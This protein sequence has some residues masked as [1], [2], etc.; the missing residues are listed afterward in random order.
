MKKALI[1]GTDDYDHCPKLKGCVRNAI[2]MAAVLRVNGNG[3]PNFDVRLITSD[4]DKVTTNILEE[5]VNE[6]FQG[7][8]ETA[9]FYFS[10]QGAINDDVTSGYLVA[11]DGGGSALG[12]SVHDLLENANRASPDIKSTVILLDI[13]HSGIAGETTTDSLG[14]PYPQLGQGVTILSACHKDGVA[15]KQKNQGRFTD[16]LI[17]GLQGAAS[18]I[19]G[20]ISPAS[21]YAH[22]DQTFDAWDQRPIYK[23]NV[24][25]SV[26]LREVEPKIPTEILRNLPLYFWTPSYQYK[27]DPSYEPNRGEESEKLKNIPVIDSNVKI[28]RQLQKCNQHG[29]VTPTSYPFMWHSAV[30]SSTVKLTALGAFYWRMAK[31]GSF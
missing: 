5:A 28:Y 4:R 22:V 6:L 17:E 13:C 16:I 14:R 10:G 30:Y 8:L 1:V 31:K 19:L 29:L 21:L 25:Q 24:Q 23:A 15:E 2:E 27:L 18:N 3:S 7:E 11:Q 20:K 12:L 26:N 9:L